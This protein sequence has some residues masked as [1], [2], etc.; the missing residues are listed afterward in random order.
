MIES[1]W[2]VLKSE[3]YNRREWDTPAQAIPAVEAW[4]YGFYNT[5]HLNSA[6]GYQTPAEFEAHHTPALTRAA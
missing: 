5:K 4:I 6:I 2:S 3:F 1:Q